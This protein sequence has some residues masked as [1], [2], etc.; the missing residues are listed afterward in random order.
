MKKRRYW[1]V[2]PNAAFDRFP[3]NAGCGMRVKDKDKN[4]SNRRV[5]DLAKL[6]V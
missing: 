4:F 2:A 3:G 6:I 1:T 5:I